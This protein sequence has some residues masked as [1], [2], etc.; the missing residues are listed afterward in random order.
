MQTSLETVPKIFQFDLLTLFRRADELATQKANEGIDRYGVENGFAAAI[1]RVLELKTRVKVLDVDDA[2]ATNGRNSRASL[3]ADEVNFFPMIGVGRTLFEGHRHA[4]AS[5][6]GGSI[7]VLANRF[8]NDGEFD[9]G[10]T[11][12]LADNPGAMLEFKFDQGPSIV[13][14]HEAFRDLHQ[15]EDLRKFAAKLRPDVAQPR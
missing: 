14:K 12:G 9:I 4:R 5:D 8:F 2:S 13:V 15:D 7:K 3:M 6:G 1:F 10:G 11:F